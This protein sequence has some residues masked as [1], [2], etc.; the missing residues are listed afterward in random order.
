MSWIELKIRKVSVSK[1]IQLEN[2]IQLWDFTN[3]REFVKS[4]HEILHKR[5]KFFISSELR[6]FHFV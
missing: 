2:E 6:E 1:L 4:K 5:G 3:L